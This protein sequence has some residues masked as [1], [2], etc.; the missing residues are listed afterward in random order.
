MSEK[1]SSPRYPYDDPPVYFTSQG[2]RYVYPADLMRSKHAWDRIKELEAF[3]E[4]H[5]LQVA[6]G[7]GPP[8]SGSSPQQ[9]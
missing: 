7:L 5:N 4:A 8:P 9:K 6:Q 2:G 1:S 3:A